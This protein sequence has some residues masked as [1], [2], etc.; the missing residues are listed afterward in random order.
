MLHVLLDV[1]GPKCINYL[2]W[3]EKV[4]DRVQNIQK[5]HNE[6]NLTKVYRIFLMN[7]ALGQLI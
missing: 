4:Y 1:N 6:V 7:K 5:N 3:E 2:R